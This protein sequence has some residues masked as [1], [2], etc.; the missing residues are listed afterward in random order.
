MA[1]STLN[2]ARILRRTHS[3]ATASLQRSIVARP[4]CLATPS[5]CRHITSS[6][7]TSSTSTQRQPSEQTN[8]AIEK[9][10]TTVEPPK[11]A[12][13]APIFDTQQ[14]VKSIEQVIAELNK[15]ARTAQSTTYGS[16][17]TFSS[18]E[19]ADPNTNSN[20]GTAQ[21]PPPPRGPKTPSRFWFYLYYILY[22]SALGSLPV[23]LLMTKSESKDLKERQ[24]WKIAVL[25]DMRDKLLRG[26]SIEEEEALLSVGMDRSKREEHVDEKYFEDLL[27]TAEKMDFVFG[28][29][30]EK[31]APATGPDTAVA[32]APAPAPPAAP[33]KPAPPKTERSYL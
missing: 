26:E 25:T 22:Y 8:E 2:A 7:T 9:P 10:P 24:E 28:K 33:R 20:Q 30:R 31:D 29:D 13:E 16:E 4:V 18:S 27:Q 23:H 6:P 12:L 11:I 1:A 17:S 14:S 3:I 32:P 19:Y 5:Q 15:D 21:P